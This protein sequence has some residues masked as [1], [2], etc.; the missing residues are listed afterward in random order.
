M[1]MHP[2][3]LL[4][5]VFDCCQQAPP[6]QRLDHRFM[7]QTPQQQLPAP[8]CRHLPLCRLTCPPLRH[9]R[10]SP[11]HRRVHS[12]SFPVV[13]LMPV[14][15]AVQCFIPRFCCASPVK[16]TQLQPITPLGPCLALI[17]ILLQTPKMSPMPS[18]RLPRLTHRMFGPTSA[19]TTPFLAW[20][21]IQ[22]L[23]CHLRC[24]P[25]LV[26]HGTG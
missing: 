15:L 26:P 19:F 23:A 18:L 13:K 20:P 21:A 5:M 4:L 6:T 16:T 7:Y 9:P 22:R 25:L 10:I 11:T 24:A 17:R 12:S 8:A 3:R 14:L 1:P 2:S